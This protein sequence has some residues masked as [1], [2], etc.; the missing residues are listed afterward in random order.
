MAHVCILFADG[1]P[2]LPGFGR[3]GSSG[4]SR[5]ESVTISEFFHSGGQRSIA[6]RHRRDRAR[7]D[8]VAVNSTVLVSPLE[9]GSDSFS[10]AFPGLTP[11]ATG[12]PARQNRACWGPRLFGPSSLRAGSP[13][14]GFRRFGRGSNEGGFVS[15]HGLSRAASGLQEIGL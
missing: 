3:C 6:V 8:R 4:L 5:R 12:T 11:G 10:F 2:H 7:G 9:R 14:L 13:G 15:G 1:A